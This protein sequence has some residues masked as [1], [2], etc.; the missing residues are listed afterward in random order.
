MY[1]NN[2]KKTW[3]PRR[4]F[5]DFQK[6]FPIPILGEEVQLSCKNDLIRLMKYQEACV[7][8]P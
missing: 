4:E 5:N 7:Y 3:W 6:Y 8:R 2:K 1:E